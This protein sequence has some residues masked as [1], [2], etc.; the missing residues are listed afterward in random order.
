VVGDLTD[1]QTLSIVGNDLSI[2]GGNT[3]GIPA[4]DWGTQV[5]QS[6]ST[7][8][9]NGTASSPLGV[10]GDLTDDQTLS[11]AGNNLSISN[12]NSV[13]LPS[14][15]STNGSNIYYNDG[16]VGIGT[17]SPGRLL[18]ILGGSGAHV[19][20]QDS[21]TGHGGGDGLLVGI[22]QS[23]NRAYVFNYENGPLRLGTN[24]ITRLQIHENGYIGVGYTGLA[25]TRILDL[26]GG[27]ESG[28][29][30][31]HTN[32]TGST[33]TDG[34]LIGV[35]GVT[36]Q[37]I[38]WNYENTGLYFAT[39]NS[40]KMIIE[41][42]GNVMIG[43][44]VPDQKLSVAGNASKSVGGALWATYSDRRLKDLHGDYNKGLSEIVTLQPVVFSYKA[45]NP[46]DLPNENIEYGLIAQEVQDIFPEAV[47]ESRKGYLQLNMNPINVAFI[48]AIKELKAANDNLQEK[49]IDLES[50]L[51]EIESMLQQ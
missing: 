25:P 4:D 39:N 9:G 26:H 45:D 8:S 1:D 16:S 33:T 2:S 3:V 10:N 34:F 7:L 14:L 42:G 23:T 24:A 43:S 49:V 32:G 11:V 28:F 19:S 17:S 37:A 5:V 51:A 48:N 13:S 31:F 36:E 38:V 47:S 50:R 35:N 20:F 12:G 44:S 27:A 22:E 40:T 21:Y 6:N 29:M 18:N 30:A 15:W 41:A 46:L